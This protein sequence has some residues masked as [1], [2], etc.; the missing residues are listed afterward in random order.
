MRFSSNKSW[1]RWYGRNFTATNTNHA[2]H[3]QSLIVRYKPAATYNRY[4]ILTVTTF[5]SNLIKLYL[6][7]PP[8]PPPPPPTFFFFVAVWRKMRRYNI[9]KVKVACTLFAG[10]WLSLWV[11]RLPPP[12]TF[13]TIFI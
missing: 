11:L 13:T 4:I 8:P 1:W 10:L 9:N 3:Y 6:L 12:I 2:H 5:V 7:T